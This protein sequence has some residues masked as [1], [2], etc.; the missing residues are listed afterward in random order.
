M[1]VK[2]ILSFIAFIIWSFVES[3]LNSG[4]ILAS[5]KL[6]GLQFENS[7]AAY[8]VSQVGGNGLG[9]VDFGFAALTYF[10]LIATGI[11]LF[12][13]LGVWMTNIKGWL[14]SIGKLCLIGLVVA[15]IVP[16]DANAFYESTDR[17]EAYTILPNQTAIWIPD[18][19]DNKTSQTQMN[20]I[21]YYNANKVA[22]RRFVVPHHKF[23]N[24]GGWMGFDAYVPDGR[25]IIVDRTQYSREWVAANHRGTSDKDQSIPCQTKEGINVSVGVS[26][27]AEV[28]EANASK[29]LYHFGVIAPEGAIT[30]KATIFTSVYHSRS[31]ADVMDNSIRPQI[32]TLICD[33]ISQRTFD[34]VNAQ[35]FKFKEDAKVKIEK[36]M[37]DFGLTLM[38][39]G[40][41]D[42]FTFEDTIQKAVNDAYIAKTLGPYATV[43]NSLASIKVQEGIAKGVTNFGLPALMTPSL[44][45]TITGLGNYQSQEHP[46]I[47]TITPS[48]HVGK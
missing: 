41:A 42:T 32:Q 7:D 37:S 35:A 24:S 40:W 2:I 19:G 20:S 38:F 45:Q 27:G 43:L 13:L 14:E 29:F 11:F 26:V 22:A 15:S 48:V 25:L 10:D 47:P 3:S 31:V 30:D 6:A 21:D 23:Q 44:I 4:L 33:E 18:V 46:T 12:T 1:K 17:A 39:F 16:Q 28:E 36:Y 5:G 8:A 34:D 9:Y